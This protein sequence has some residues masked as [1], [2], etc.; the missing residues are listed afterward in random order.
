MNLSRIILYIFLLLITFS[1][2]KDKEEEPQYKNGT[3]IVEPETRISNQY[4][5]RVEGQSYW[6][7]NLP[8][9]YQNPNYHNRPILVRFELTGE[10]Q[11][12]N[13]PG[14]SDLPV[15]GY[16]VDVVRILS[17]REP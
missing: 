11:D 17:I 2:K 7:E 13:V 8:Q 3:I 15:F 9:E 14:P 5:I 16:T 6:P 4:L 1:C 12:V 10:T